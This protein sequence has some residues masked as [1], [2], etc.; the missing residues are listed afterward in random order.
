MG[1]SLRRI[2]KRITD[3][4]GGVVNQVNPLDQG[5]TFQHPSVVAPPRGQPAPSAFQ[6]ATHSG[7]SNFV[8]QNVIKPLGQFPIDASSQAYN[9]VVAPTFNLP[10]LN[11]GQTSFNPIVQN[12]AN[13]LGAT[14]SLHQTVS[15]G[16]QTG[17]TL[18]GGG[19]A[20][21]IE[22]GI[23]GVVAPNLA[24]EA[25]IKT[26][27]GLGTRAIPKTPLI[28]KVGSN[29]A[30]GAGFNAS[31]AAGQGAKPID[32]AKSAGLGAGF[33]AAVPVAGT[34]AKPVIKL[35]AQKIDNR[36][37]LNQVGGVEKDV[38]KTPSLSS[39]KSPATPPPSVKLKNPPAIPGQGSGIQKANIT[40]EATQ[41]A[42]VFN[43]SPE[44][45][46]RQLT[47][48]KQEQGAMA[49]RQIQQPNMRVPK[50]VKEQLNPQAPFKRKTQENTNLNPMK[51]NIPQVQPGDYGRARINPQVAS[52]PI[53]FSASQTIKKIDKLNPEEKSNFWKAVENPQHIKSSK[54]KEA[55]TRWNDLSNRVHATSQALGG[56][57]NFVKNYARHN[58]DLT[59]PAQAAKYEELVNARGGQSVD[60]YAFGGV[61]NQNRAF[62][63]VTEGEAAGFKLKNPG[64]PAQDVREY[65][66]SVA[67][68]LS[69][70]ALAKSF[71]EADMHQPLRNRS[72]DLGN[73]QTVPVSEQGLKEMRGYERYTPST[74]R[75]IKGARTLNTALKTS[76]LSA[77]QFHPVN[78]SVL[79]AGPTLALKGH[80]VAA[81]KGVGRTFR[82]LLPGGTGSVD[83]VM[84]RALKDGMVEKAARLGMPYGERGYNVEGSYLKGGVGHK[85]V[86]EKQMPMMHDQ[87][88]RSVVRDLEK[89]GIPLESEEARQAGIVANA[90][91]GFINKEALNMSPKVRQAMTDVM[92]AGQFTPSKGIVVGKSGA[93]G[94]AGAYARADVASNVAQSAAIIA[95]LGYLTNQ[96]SN[97]IRDII[98]KALIDPAVST[99]FKDSKGN[100]QELR[101]PLTNTAEIAHILGIKLVRQKDGHL[102]VSW[103]PKNT[104]DTLTEW[105]R[106]RLSPVA[107]DAVKLKTNTNFADKPLYDPNAPLGTKAIQAATTIVQGH[108]PIGAQGLAY[109]GAVKK[110]LPGSAKEILDANTPGSNSLL[111]SGLSSVGFTPRTDK[112]VGKALETNRYFAGV[113]EALS[114]A[115]NNSEKTALQNYLGS[116]KN[117]V[118]GK[119][120]VTPNP[121]DTS[122]KAKDLLDAPKTIDILIDMNKK[123]KDQ[124]SKVD[125]LWTRPKSEITA[126]L[127]YQTMP[128]GG[129]DRKH[130]I[131]QNQGWY[132]A[133]AKERSKFFSSLPPGDPN[134]PAAPIEFPTPPKDVAQKQEKFFSLSDSGERAKFLQENPQVQ[135]QLD[136]QVDYNNQMRE[137]Q[138]YSAL[139]TFPTASKNVQKII[140]TYNAIPK[141]G[142]SRGGN[143]Y[144]SQWIQ[145]HPKEYADMTQYF[146]QASLYGLEQD[147]AQ[148]QYKNS[149]FS[150]KGLKDIVSLAKYDI[151]TTKDSN[152]NTIYALGGSGA[153]S[154]GNSSGYGS[155]AKSDPFAN[156]YKYA[157]RAKNGSKAKKSRVSVRGGS[158]GKIAKAP[159]AKVTIKSSRV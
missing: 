3:I 73:G 1:L 37:P 100:T 157:I 96:T 159:K 38:N 108:L 24:R 145:A 42:H 18:G 103:K 129:A 76:L 32:I 134:K 80:P 131:T 111:K 26:T 11:T 140:D 137:A 10:K 44:E 78:I 15:S 154:S 59:D 23:T 101:T 142:G 82:P 148:A 5:R 61:N 63:S 41:Y 92:L 67:G 136:K 110:R 94:T 21:G 147:A 99:P 19:L 39:G 50:G 48:L 40:P 158:K 124:G 12:V 6:Q 13:K 118:T 139:D 105:M 127:E 62:Q 72:F 27:L 104:P 84:E 102:G 85:L 90:T 35:A 25:A 68:S 45:A 146:T 98:L 86:F 115:R 93:K 70:Q 126:T 141:G 120:D 149:G 107:S 71:T 56:N 106:A 4:A 34:V 128:P 143:K 60:P 152:G 91:M 51:V 55:V 52:R 58:W 132:E 29:A 75:A 114:K 95:G 122:R 109:T 135:T 83:R 22:S 121:H 53:K 17:L 123:L 20:K 49:G 64:N 88:V 2:G 54:L 89:K 112:T 119:Y 14:G 47:K 79:R 97:S 77:S 150:Q 144:R 65:A 28:A 46:S 151:G 81:V 36:V 9:R 153:G 16:I 125:P 30:I 43:I 69:K 138:G 113:D 66:D 155:Y 57:T 7:V 8:G 74:N 117:P 133:L 33:G 116:K 31:A 87:V 156:S 130:W